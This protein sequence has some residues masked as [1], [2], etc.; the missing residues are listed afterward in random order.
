MPIKVNMTAEQINLLTDEIIQG[1]FTVDEKNA[2]NVFLKNLA[3]NDKLFTGLV[4]QAEKD[5]SIERKMGTCIKNELINAAA[6]G[7]MAY[8]SRCAR[9]YMSIT[10]KYKGFTHAS[11][12]NKDLADS[13]DK[14]ARIIYLTLKNKANNIRK[15]RALSKFFKEGYPDLNPK[16]IDILV[17]S[18]KISG[19]NSDLKLITDF[20]K[21]LHYDFPEK[22]P[23]VA[24]QDTKAHS[25]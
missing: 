17:H 3:V 13:I 5:T 4:K 21:A 15:M 11:K 9:I 14:K 6:E 8:P 22:M 7:R 20:I 18:G 24:Q 16:A 1:G 19:T 10:K 25:A 2:I 23:T 12:Q